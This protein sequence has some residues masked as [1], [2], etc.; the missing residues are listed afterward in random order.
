MKK[1]E[2]VCRL[3]VV[4]DPST[5]VVIRPPLVDVSTAR[6]NIVAKN[7]A[8]TIVIHG[9]G[10][11]LEAAV[12]EVHTE[13]VAGVMRLERD[14]RA[15]VDVLQRDIARWSKDVGAAFEGRAPA[16]EPSVVAELEASAEPEA[17]GASA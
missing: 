11:T 10:S 8:R 12:D 14:M 17:E 15:K 2:E 13:I 16:R 9:T 3:A 1:L 4:L 7:K 5:D 6:W